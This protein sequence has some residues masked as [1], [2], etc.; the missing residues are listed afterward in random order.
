MEANVPYNRET[1]ACRAR[2]PSA[3]YASEFRERAV[4][5]ALTESVGVSEGARRLSAPLT[6][7]ANWV[8]SAKAGKLHEIGK[9]QKPLTE[10]KA[11]LARVQ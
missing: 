2:I 4:K 3:V 7:L 11:E 9:E 5:L 10:M 6:T 1:E 8:R